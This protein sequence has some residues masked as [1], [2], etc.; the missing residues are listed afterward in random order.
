M[1]C[2]GNDAKFIPGIKTEDGGFTP[3]QVVTTPRGE[4]FVC[5]Q[6]VETATGT[7]VANRKIMEKSSEEFK[8]YFILLVRSGSSNHIEIRR[9]EI[10]SWRHTKW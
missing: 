7:K 1:K 10:C 5:G 6:I 4:E 9:N 8:K 2:L 3:G